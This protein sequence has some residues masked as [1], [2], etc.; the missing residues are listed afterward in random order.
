MAPRTCWTSWMSRSRVSAC[1]MTSHTIDWVWEKCQG[2]GGG[3]GR[4]PVAGKPVH[5]L[6]SPPPSVLGTV[7]FA[8]GSPDACLQVSLLP[9]GGHCEVRGRERWRLRGE[10]AALRSW[11]IG[12]RLP[13][14][15]VGSSL[16]CP[17]SPDTPV[18]LSLLGEGG[19]ERCR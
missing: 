15:L 14:G 5:L 12:S 8:S 3:V 2:S 4:E 7:L 1:R 6:P 9:R 17:R 19:R 10:E 11:W 13:S 18:P 16:Y